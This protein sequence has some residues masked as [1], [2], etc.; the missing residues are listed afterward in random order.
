MDVVIGH[1]PRSTERIS[2]LS[3]FGCYGNSFARLKVVLKVWIRRPDNH[4]LQAM[5]N[6]VCI[7]STETEIWAIL[8]YF[9]LIFIAMATPLAPSKIQ[10]GYLNSL[11]PYSLRIVCKKIPRFLAVN[12]N[13][14]ILAYCC[15]IALPWQPPWLH[16][17]L[18]S[19]FEV[20]DHTIH[21]KNSSISCI[22]LK[23]VR[24]WLIFAQ[25]WLSWQ[26]P[27]LTHPQH[28][29]W[30]PYHT[31]EKFLIFLHRIKICAILAYF[32]S[33]FGCHGNSLGSL[34]ILDSSFKFT[35]PENLI[36]HAKNSSISCT[37]LITVLYWI[38]FAHIGCHGNS[39]AS[40]KL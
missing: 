10:V 17:T 23:S 16:W 37:E 11:N 30:K 8:V 6:I 29:P 34:E 22:K 31:C 9:C 2:S 1:I 39:L 38:I 19:I 21:A 3:K 32:L 4:T 7:S 18:D 13:A 27:G 26:L 15:P 24:F 35:D 33:K 20:A 36:I 14:C 25:I 40:L 12:W 28:Q 5:T